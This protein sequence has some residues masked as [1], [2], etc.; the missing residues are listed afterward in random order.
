MK[1]L[2]Y[3]CHSDLAITEYNDCTVRAL[4]Q[5]LTG[6]YELAHDICSQYG[7]PNSRGMNTWSLCREM[8]PALSFEKMTD[9]E[10]INP[11]NSRKGRYTAESF[12]KDFVGKDTGYNYYL[13]TKNH[14]IG[15]TSEGISDSRNFS[16]RARLMYAFKIKK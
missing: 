12:I 13:V 5:T 8:L 6:D 1:N 16:G 10:L 7:R 11:G 9:E 15:V 2:N 14:A 3:I 4:A